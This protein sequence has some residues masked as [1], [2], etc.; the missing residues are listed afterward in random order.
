M[1]NNA[2]S[3]AKGRP[4]APSRVRWFILLIAAI[5]TIG[6]VV[7]W[8]LTQSPAVATPPSASGEWANQPTLGAVSAPVTVVEFADFQCPYCAQFERNFFQ[9]LRDHYIATGQVR[10]VFVNDVVLGK[11][12]QTAAELGEAIY[13]Q[14]PQNFW[15]YYQNVY[16][17][18]GKEGSGWASAGNLIALAT[19]VAPEL[20]PVQLRQALDAHTYAKDVAQDKQLAKDHGVS[21]TPTFLVNG[22]KVVGTRWSELE[23]TIRA[24]LS[25]ASSSSP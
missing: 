12:S 13:H 19:A 18:Q 6:S 11:D 10:F 7:A 8:R 15:L 20:N 23:A 22:Q 4:P 9:Q 21:G 16:A 3:T 25:S 17:H 2:S 1:Q 5:V 14:N 24:A